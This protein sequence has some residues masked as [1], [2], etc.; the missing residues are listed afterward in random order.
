MKTIDDDNDN[1]D[2]FDRGG[3]TL[4]HGMECNLYDERKKDLESKRE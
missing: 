3:T 2:D 4:P 1:D